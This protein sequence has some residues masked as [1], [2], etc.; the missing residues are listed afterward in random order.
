M[1]AGA[2]GKAAGGPRMRVLWV[3]DVFPHTGRPYKGAWMVDLGRALARHVEVVVLSPR[4]RFLWTPKG[5]FLEWYRGQ[6]AVLDHGPVRAL[7]PTAPAVPWG[8]IM[9]LQSLSMAAAFL[10]AGRREHRRSPF[11]LIHGHFIIPGGFSAA[12]MA[13]RLGLPLVVT[14]HGSDVNEFSHV[15]HLRRLFLWSCRQASFCTAVSRDLAGRLKTMGFP[16]VSWI[17][18]GCRFLGHTASEPVRGRILF[19]GTLYE[20]KAPDVL[21]RAFVKVRREIPSATL[22]LV[23]E[24][25]ELER[26][27][28]ESIRLGVVGSLRILGPL[29]HEGVL[30]L[31][32][33]ADVFC[34]PSRREGWP[35][36]IL[37]AMAA[38]LP[39]VGSDI[40]G[41]REIVHTGDLGILTPPG[42]EDTLARALV[43]ALRRPWDRER[44]RAEAQ[45]YS[46]D[47]I[48]EQYL[49]VYREAIA[50]R[51]SRLRRSAIA[52]AE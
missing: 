39:I 3:S 45:K 4:Y 47:R 5:S 9:A 41:I 22:D 44:I 19:V 20:G 25:P 37:E 23:G 26:C 8:F 21:L 32:R 17:P 31:M 15:S 11:D 33:E 52:G 51:R 29:P 6:P 28:A 10:P 48:A 24:G 43:E 2:S 50:S 7:Y 13:R 36:V 16:K 38:G 46:W 30:H 1:L 35:L 27:R 12:W 14:G 49:E 34:L 18:N 40:G 42:D